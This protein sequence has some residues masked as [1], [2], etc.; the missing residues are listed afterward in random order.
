[1]L[2]SG[3]AT[4]KASRLD[5][6]DDA[7]ELPVRPFI[8]RTVGDRQRSEAAVENLEPREEVQQLVVGQ[9]DWF[10]RGTT[11]DGSSDAGDELERIERFGDV[12]VGSG[13]HPSRHV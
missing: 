9:N 10:V 12:V 1:M 8:R 5:C 13:F 11:A 2:G 6:H 3:V 7:F 4:G